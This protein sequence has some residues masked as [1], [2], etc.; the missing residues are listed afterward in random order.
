MLYTMLF[1]IGLCFWS[2][3][4]VITYRLKDFSL[5]DIRENKKSY[6]L[7]VTSILTG[8]SRCTSC[9]HTLQ[10]TD[11]IPIVSYIIHKGQC[12][13]CKKN[14]SRL[15]PILEIGSGIV[16]ALV[17]YLTLQAWLPRV[18]VI[19]W[20]A[21]SWLLYL[22]MIFDIQTW[23]LHETIWLKSLI[24]TGIL[25]YLTPG[26]LRYYAVQRWV[27]FLLF[28]LAIYYLARMY[29]RFRWKKREDWFGI[30]DVRLSPIIWTL[31]GL[32]HTRYTHSPYFPDS[33]QLFQ[34]YIISTWLI[35]LAFYFLQKLYAPQNNSKEIPFFPGMVIWLWIIMV[36]GKYV[37]IN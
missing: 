26:F 3:G 13:Y 28:F 18:E 22:L 7:A 37:L 34:R 1:I 19:L 5:I 35:W 24:T 20:I 6:R 14:I 4:S 32:I 27:L 11:L 12:Q 25:L 15:Y 8:R 30:W 21:I 17:W 2:F 29:V 10:P 36:L 16:F 33:L 9:H 31:F 23:I